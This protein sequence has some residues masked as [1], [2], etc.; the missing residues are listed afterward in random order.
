M[1]RWRWTAVGIGVT[2]AATLTGCA[3]AGAEA[4]DPAAA[5]DQVVGQVEQLTVEVI[6]QYPH[7]TAAFTQGLELHEGLL[8]EGTGLEGE[9]DI[10]IVEPET[11]EVRQIVD[12]P[13]DVFGEGITIVG[14]QIWQITW[15]EQ[16]AYLRDRESLAELDQ[17]SYTGE[18]WGICHDEGNDRLIM[19]NG[20]SELTFR[21]P[22]TFEPTGTVTVTRDGQP[23]VNIN[24]L[25][26][27]GDRVWANIWLTDE[28]VRINPETG[29]VEAVVNGAG[30]LT[31]EEAATADVLNGIAVVPGL[32]TN[33]G[34]GTFMIT[35]KLWPWL[36][37]VRFVPAA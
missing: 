9:S 8:Y 34:P 3:D 14:D 35:G 21:D 22:A 26:C 16:I 32:S 12:L 27:V 6:E 18:G 11:G 13:A 31:P 1:K 28:I 23:V 5:P 4:L 36:F 10:R 24:E 33:S 7:D 20:T 19:S 2:L 25:E 15:Q 30:L 37:L 29:T 17:V